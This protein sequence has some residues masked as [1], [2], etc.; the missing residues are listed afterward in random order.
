MTSTPSPCV[1]QC[2]LIPF[3][4]QLRGLPPASHPFRPKYPELF[5]GRNAGGVTLPPTTGEHSPNNS[6]TESTVAILPISRRGLNPL[7]SFAGPRFRF[8][9]LRGQWEQSLTRTQFLACL[10]AAKH[11]N[12]FRP[13]YPELIHGRNAGSFTLPKST[14]ERSPNNS[15]TESSVA[16]LPISRRGLN[17]FAQQLRGF[18]LSFPATPGAVGTV[19]NS[20]T[21]SCLSPGGETWVSISTEISGAHFRK[22][23]RLVHTSTNNWRAFAD[24]LTNG[25]QRCHSS[26]FT[27][28]PEPAHSTASPVLSFVSRHSGGRGN[29]P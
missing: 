14:G 6:R 1:A 25:I 15:R 26:D 10:P 17:P 16:I 11:G 8:P 21:I 2:S 4:Q 19:L 28:R 29:S 27:A 7:N 9:Q 24:Q 22:E 18:S 12:P 5:H 23:R 20:G 13:K 3:A